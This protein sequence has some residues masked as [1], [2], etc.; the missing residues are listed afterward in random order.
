VNH[1]P[2]TNLR[3]FQAAARQ[4]DAMRLFLQRWAFDNSIALITNAEENTDG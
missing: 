4:N 2:T 1:I 3:S